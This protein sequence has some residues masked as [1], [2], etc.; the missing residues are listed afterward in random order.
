MARKANAVPSQQVTDNAQDIG[1]VLGK[2]E[3]IEKKLSEQQVELKKENDEIMTKLDELTK[4]MG[5]W[6]HTLWL[7]KA[8]IA[9]VP[10]IL[11][12]NYTDLTQMWKDM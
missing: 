6:R 4:I 7:F 5:F 3:M 8:I 10:L 11:A 1:Y 12:A 2:M 9:S